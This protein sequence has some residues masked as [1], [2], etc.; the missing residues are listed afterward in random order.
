[1]CHSTS[2]QS[3]LHFPLR[4][5]RF[6]RYFVATVS[7]FVLIQILQNVIASAQT[8]TSFSSSTGNTEL[9]RSI[10]NTSFEI[11]PLSI[12]CVVILMMVVMF[13][14]QPIHVYF[15][16][17][18]TPKTITPIPLLNIPVLS[19][20]TFNPSPLQHLKP[21]QFPSIDR[22]IFT[23][24]SIISTTFHSLE[25][26]AEVQLLPLS[27]QSL[28]QLIERS[29]AEVIVLM[30]NSMQL[31]SLDMTL[32][33]RHL[34]D[35]HLDAVKP[36]S[37]SPEIVEKR[38]DQGSDNPYPELHRF[39][40]IMISD[41]TMTSSM[42]YHETSSRKGLESSSGHHCYIVRRSVLLSLLKRWEWLQTGSRYNNEKVQVERLYT[43]IGMS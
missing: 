20:Q 22:L 33:I 37:L 10:S 40:N 14:L 16:Q 3:K 23:D 28:T 12:S 1:M 9:S 36:K 4:I 30:D 6:I 43:V 7:C 35:N 29:M 42:P 39:L 31:D 8:S 17:S 38:M 15:S 5:Y 13:L 41:R 27:S 24:Q 2:S 34:W 19:D 25:S 18:S 11:T 32:G 26:V 21:H